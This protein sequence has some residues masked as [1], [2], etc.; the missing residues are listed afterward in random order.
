MTFSVF[1]E[2]YVVFC[3]FGKSR[4]GWLA[5]QGVSHRLVHH[6]GYLAQ[7]SS[8]CSVF[9]CTGY[10]HGQYRRA[11]G[12]QSNKKTIEMLKFQWIFVKFGGDI[13]VISEP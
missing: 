4:T 2:E 12:R 8:S 1:G 5:M 13:K 7:A 10:R 9:R 6:A 11:A 3:T